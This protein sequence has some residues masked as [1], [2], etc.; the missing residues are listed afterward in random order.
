M[1]S[2][3][4]FKINKQEI[5]AFLIISLTFF[6]PNAIASAIIFLFFAVYRFKIDKRMPGR[7]FYFYFIIYGIVVGLYNVV[8]NNYSSYSLIKQLYYCILPFFY[9]NVGMI[10][11][12]TSKSSFYSYLFKAIFIYSIIDLLQV[13][14]NMSNV[15]TL[16]LNEFRQQIGTGSILPA[17]G[18][19][20]II[21]FSKEINISKRQ[22]TLSSLLM[23]FSLLVH[24]SRTHLLE[25]AIL[26]L[27]SGVIKNLRK[28]WKI[29]IISLATVVVIY[30]IAP[31]F[32][33]YFISKIQNTFTEMNYFDADWTWTNINHNWRGYENYCAIQQ[34]SK[35]NLFE[36]LFGGGFGTT[37]DVHGNAFL[38][39]SEDTLL[40]LH[41]GYLT[42]L[43]IWGIIGLAMYIL[44][45]IRLYFREKEIKTLKYRNLY[46]GLAIIV[47]IDSITVRSAFFSSSIYI[48]L[49]LLSAIKHNE[50]YCY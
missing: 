29:I 40:F 28:F 11:S 32:F 31:S 3:I 35:A 7:M 26:I 2:R 22:R 43:L 18:L 47:M 21:F 41:N 49:F 13:I 14:T 9:W 46:R 34:F 1:N 30:F 12:K 19:Y 10:F 44:W 6:L 45:E 8:S 50:K 33:N 37:L 20:L 17:I 15:S 39:S 16:S 42:H 27:F 38:V 36:K 23:V 24:F 25:F 48:I 4:S 5:T